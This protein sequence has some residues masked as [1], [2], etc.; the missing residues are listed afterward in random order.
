MLVA[1]P[2]L[3]LCGA[4]TLLFALLRAKRN[5]SAKAGGQVVMCFPILDELMSKY[6]FPDVSQTRVNRLK[7]EGGT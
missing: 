7:R 3:S 6:R 2:F 5:P 4:K 1:R